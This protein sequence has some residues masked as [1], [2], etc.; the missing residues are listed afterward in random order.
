M[1]LEIACPN[2]EYTDGMKIYCKA[3]GSLCGNQRFKSCKGWWVLT[4]NARKCPKWKEKND[5]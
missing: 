1:K 5:G 3:T 2:G 4:D